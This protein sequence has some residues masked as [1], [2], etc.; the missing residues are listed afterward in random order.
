MNEKDRIK[1]NV[2]NP[3][4]KKKK[5]K[6]ERKKEKKGFWT[7]SVRVIVLIISLFSL[8]LCFNQTHNQIHTLSTLYSRK[9]QYMNK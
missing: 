9:K 7:K 2:S 5:K 6:K 4:S 8:R 1:R 3:S